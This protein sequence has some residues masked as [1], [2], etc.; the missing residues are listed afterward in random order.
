[1]KAKILVLMIFLSGCTFLMGQTYPANPDVIISCFVG[2]DIRTA[3]QNTAAAVISDPYNTRVEVPGNV[4]PTHDKIWANAGQ[5][6]SVYGIAYSPTQNRAYAAA[7]VKSFAMLGPG[8]GG[9]PAGFG[10]AG[11]IYAL[12]PPTSGGGPST[13][14]VLLDIGAAAGTTPRASNGSGMNADPASFNHIGRVGWGDI[15]VSPDGNTLWAMNLFNRSLYKIALPSGTILGTY[16]IPGITGGPTYNST[17]TSNENLD[18]RPFG[19]KVTATKVFVGIISSGESVSLPSTHN[20]NNCSSLTTPNLGAHVFEFNVTS[21]TYNLTPVLSFG[22][23]GATWNDGQCSGGDAGS[24]E[25]KWYY[26]LPA[27]SAY[28]TSG[29]Q[30]LR[31]LPRPVIADIEFDGNNMIIGLRNISK[32][33]STVISG[34]TFPSGGQDAVQY[35]GF[36]GQMLKACGAAGG[37]WTIESGGQCP[38]GTAGYNS[39]SFFRNHYAHDN[40]DF[41]GSLAIKPGEN[42]IL[43][44]MSPGGDQGSVGFIDATT[45]EIKD[46]GGL[47]MNNTIYSQQAFPTDDPT[48][49]GK[50]AGLGDLDLQFNAVAICMITNVT[51]T[52]GTCNPANNRYSVSGQ[53]IFSN[54]PSTGTLTV[55]IIGGGTQVFNAPFTSPLNYTITGQISDGGNK[56]INAVFSADNTCIGTV[57]YTAPV[58]C[59]P[60]GVCNCQEYI[61]LN[62]PSGGGKVHK[63]LVNADGSLTEVNA[64]GV[65]TPTNPLAWYDNN[66]TGDDLDEPH[67]IAFDLNG[68]LYIAETSSGDVR[69][70]DCE[71]N[72]FPESNFVISGEGGWN[73]ASIGNT[74]YIN[75]NSQSDVGAFNLCTGNYINGIDNCEGE[76]NDWGFYYDKRTGYFYSAYK[77]TGNNTENKAAVLRYTAADFGSGVCIP[78]WISPGDGTLTVGVKETVPN[79]F[80][81]GMTTDM[82]GNLYI[83]ERQSNQATARLLKYNSNGEFVAATAY[84]GTDGD[85]GWYLAAGVAYSETC[86]C[87]HVSTASNND[88]C[89]S[90]FDLNLNYLGASVP[91]NS[92]PGGFTAAKAIGILKECCPTLQSTFNRRVCAT[93]GAK[94]FLN[95]EAFDDCD[96]VVCGSSWVPQGTLT[97]M[98]F[99]PCD[100]SVT[101]TG[102][103]CGTF[104]LSLG[105]SPGKGC[106]AQ[107][108]MFT[109]CA[110]TPAATVTP[111]QGTCTGSTPNNNASIN[112]TGATF[113]TRYGFSTGATYTGPNFAGAT[114][115]VGG[116]ATI[117]N[118]VHNTQYTVRVFLR[119]N[120]FV[121]YTVMTPAITCNSCNIMVTCNPMPQTNCTPINGSASITVTGGQGTIT[122]L[123]SSGET[124]SSI[125]GKLSGTYTVTVTDDFLPNCTATCQAVITNTTTN[126][127]VTCSKMDNSNCATPNGTATATATGVAYLWSNGGT[128]SMITGL[129]N[130]TYTVTV[131]STTTGC[132]NT[133]SA[134]VA[135]TTTLP[136][137]TCTPMD[138]TNCATPNGSAIVTTNANQILWSTGATTAN[139]TGL[140]AGTYTV[141][142]TNTTTSCTNTCQAIVGSTVT[143]PT[144]TCAKTD[145]SNCATPN[146]TATVT[147]TGV[148]YL[149]SNGGT[150]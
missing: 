98:T 53:V 123:W 88:D 112:I 76:G 120:C 108:S 91:G 138:N 117:P 70:L 82:A 45:G 83:V 75:R 73:F 84:D 7:Y 23:Q 113:V 19:L 58:S 41:G 86:N 139:I 49:F 24:N 11:A 31:D 47:W 78:E 106:T 110:G 68:F 90:S 135:T 64:S 12:T 107:T 133:C 61:Y 62:E 129:S 104:A 147:A 36:G 87:L 101:I 21:S 48:V 22:F 17:Y 67:G 38:T 13:V 150:T 125:S 146:G 28:P 72:I 34:Y 32:D 92:G 134:I 65:V 148:T 40:W 145:N 81:R 140:S 4:M 43:I 115:I 46:N 63:Y 60:A 6:G 14:T 52:P 8:N 27:N 30:W 2:G 111:V 132:T 103:G 119:A 141:T 144:V 122:Y 59:M 3:P 124:T 35:N 94:Y 89:V 5:V 118:L 26:W 39:I 15:D 149:W 100:N 10:S 50:A 128:T 95:V 80:M 127:T 57:N 20:T 79:T 130:A 56:T 1:M 71:G 9:N 142:V 54:P 51:A 25:S 136:T 69:K 126:P 37:P 121:D 85:G 114:Q 116:T 42:E 97:G 105:A 96:G 16:P 93:V 131:T 99:D 137:A 74:L 77:G 109:I 44:P 55:S 102:E 66:T 29:G 143:P 33:W 18:F